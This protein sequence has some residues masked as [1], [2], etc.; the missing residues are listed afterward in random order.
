LKIISISLDVV[1][2]SRNTGL[3]TQHAILQLHTDDGIT[4]LGEMSDFSHLPQYALDLEDL[5]HT[6]ETHLIGCNP[7]DL[8]AINREFGRMF[9]EMMYIYEKGAF[10]RSGIDIALHDL[11]GKACGVNVSELIGGRLRE[12]LKVCYPIFRQSTMDEV[13]RNLAIVK[14]KLEEGFD[15]F[16]LY[17]GANLDADEAFLDRMKS[18]F[19]HKVTVKSLDFSNVLD[20]KQSLQA[21]RRLGGYGISLIESPALRN[22]VEG[23]K[24]FRLNVDYPVSEHVWSFRQ[25]MELIRYDAVDIFNIAMVF[26]GGFSGARKAAAMAEMAGKGCLIGTTQELGL[27]TAA[28]AIFGGSLAHLNAVSDPT[29]PKL[30]T[31][32][33][34]AEPVRYEDGYLLLPDRSKPGLGMELDSSKLER[35]KAAGF[36]TKEHSA[37]SLLDRK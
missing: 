22:D 10:V 24:H 37:Q 25:M 26:I 9:P 36:T 2:I 12:K 3:F 14:Q 5:R 20:W 28:Q 18:E 30:Y 29:G 13:D 7:F 11:I 21:V 6:L 34:V 32:D 8:V 15:V 23:L 27:G 19:G 16:R 33:V 17:A 1:N 35:L 4:G 31:D